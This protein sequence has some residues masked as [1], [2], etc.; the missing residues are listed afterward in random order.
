MNPKTKRGLR[1]KVYSRLYDMEN[2]KESRNDT[3]R[4]IVNDFEFYMKAVIDHIEN[5]PKPSHKGES[6]MEEEKNGQ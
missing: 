4:D 3:A 2:T 6:Q 5:N 1:K